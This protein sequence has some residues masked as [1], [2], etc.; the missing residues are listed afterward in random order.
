MKTNHHNARHM[1]MT[2][3]ISLLMMALARPASGQ[4]TMDTLIDFGSDEQIA[5]ITVNDG[6]SIRRTDDG[7]LE[8]RITPFAEHGNKWPV[9]RFTQQ[10]FGGSVNFAGHSRLETVLH[11]DSKGMSRV[12]MQFASAD[13]MTRNVDNHALM[14]PGHTAMPVKMGIDVIRD[15]DPSDIVGIQLIFRPRDNATVYR[16][17]PFRLVYD[18]AVGSA[19]DRLVS[20]AQQI[21]TQFD[22]VTRQ[23]PDTLT[24]EQQAAKAALAQRVA[25][26]T[27]DIAAA[28]EQRF[29]KTYRSLSRRVSDVVG[30]IARLRFMS[31]GPLWVWQPDR[32][33]NIL[34]D[35]GPELTAE[36]LGRLELS[37]AGNEFRDSVIAISAAD[38]DLSLD[39]AVRFADETKLPA[40]TIAIR[41]TTYIKGTRPEPTG[42]AL[43]RVEGPVSLPAGESRQL[44][45]RFDTRTARVPP[46][47]HAFELTIRDADNGIERSVPGE[48]TVWDFD[49]PSYDV[50]PNNSYAI[51]GGRLGTGDLYRQAIEHMK[52]YGINYLFVETPVL[53]R[54]TGLDDDW[55]IT[56]YDDKL[57]MTHMRQ[58]IA[59]WEAAP[60]DDQLNFIFAIL[61]FHEL[62]LERE[63]YAFPNERWKH[64]FAQWFNHFK[65]LMEKEGI[66]QSRWMLVLADESGEPALM[67]LEIPLAEAIKSIDPTV[68]ISCNTSTILSDTLWS[69]RLFK[70]FDMFQPH[71]GYDLPLEWLKLSGKPLWVY[72]CDTSLPLMGRDLYSYYRVYPWDMLERGFV[73]T[74]FWTYYSAPHDRPWDEDFQGCQFIYLHPEQG[75]VHSRR[76]EMAREGFDDYRYVAALRLA[77]ATAGP[78]AAREAESLIDNAVEDITT[79]RQDRERCETWRARIAERI[80]SLH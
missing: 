64:V 41:Y 38:S 20:T 69:M 40:D 6:V 17:E 15:N 1:L 43:L 18:P 10:F 22:A 60:G 25:S 77:A 74:G 72:Q 58:A 70:A 71:L 33:P 55:N 44:W 66:D 48:L 45:I 39:I 62:G 50:L 32:Y 7:M 31:A 35:T 79:H 57:L 14:I 59:A 12:D 4:T 24:P 46:G 13:D 3:G 29:N 56:G 80:L 37:M 23:L 5:T 26:L 11:H 73:G 28:R 65:S 16:I 68:R 2:A 53:L 52:M 67:N 61:N 47:R 30:E 9:V 34:R 42:D 21:P 78:D 8:V 63:G 51:L 54:P 75:L 19:A 49:L 76:Y 27:H 36:P